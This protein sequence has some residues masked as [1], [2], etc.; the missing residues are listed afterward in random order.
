MDNKPTGDIIATVAAFNGISQGEAANGIRELPGLSVSESVGVKPPPVDIIAEVCRDKKMP[1]DAFM[2]FNPEVAKRGRGKQDCA[3][4]PVF[5][6]SGAIHSHFDFVPGHKGFCARGVGM[7]GIFFPGRLP[8]P[9]EVWHI[10]EGCKDAAALVGLGLNA[11]GLPTS[12][13]ADKYCRLFNCVHVV[14]VPDLDEVGRNGAQRTG[15]NL[16]GIAAS[17]RVV[18]LPGEITATKGDD[19]RDDSAGKS[20]LKSRKK[21]S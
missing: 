14:L 4:V 7:S 20:S 10:V 1:I 11:C 18:R 3:R 2:Q 15:G 6:E 19:V 5:D 8:Q 21:I 17:V 12:Y 9:G 16:K 13:M